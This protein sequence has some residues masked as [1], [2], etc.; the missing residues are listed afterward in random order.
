MDFLNRAWIQIRDLFLSMT[1]AA[2]VTTAVLLGVIVVSLGYLFTSRVSTT[3]SYLMGGE[4]FSPSDLKAME[5]AF[6]KAG[7][8]SYQIEGS[9]VRIP[10]GQEAKYMAALVDHNALPPEF[11][12][13]LAKAV[14]T[15]SPFLTAKQIESRKIAAKERE[16]ALIIRSL[17][18]IE[19]AAVLFD[20]QTE[21]GLRAGVVKTASVAVKALG[22][23]PLDPEQ[24]R[25]IRH[26][27]AASFAGMKPDNVTVADL[28][29]QTYTGSGDPASGGS[30]AD[31]PYIARKREHEKDW[32]LKILKALAYVPGITVTTNVEL[33]RQQILRKEDIKHD[34]KPVPIRVSETESSR[35]REGGGPGG[36]PGYVAQQ[37]K[38]NAPT[39][40][41]G[42]TGTSEQEEQSKSETVNALSTQRS[43][44]E[45]I[46]LTPK[47]VTAAIGVPMSYFARVW[48]ERNPAAPGEAPKPPDAAQLAKIR[49]E[50]LKKIRDHVAAILPSAEGVADKTELVT[51][52]EF[53]D[54]PGPEIP[55]PSWL[56]RFWEFLATSWATLGMLGLAAMSLW[57]IRSLSR[58]SLPPLPSTPNLP[59]LPTS[60]KEEEEAQ[61][62]PR[63][64]RFAAGGPSLKDELADLVREDPEAA[65]NILRAWIGTPQ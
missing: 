19:K 13:F 26:L 36:R 7:L 41:S 59:G 56:E 28:N 53:Q 30:A 27:V 9:R 39:S 24:V 25:K 42:R 22:A 62:G 29:G 18:G 47:R 60:E 61:K 8:S 45:E 5:A 1:P 64:A 15:S 32:Q 37:P 23:Q 17:P 40:V 49:D 43:M 10:R 3:E 4:S 12:E 58:A 55:T 16:L 2:R 50:E 51:V 33:D 63:F 65:A 48:E 20:A 52:T 46:G 21:G 14:E 38:A 34:P 57:M 35:T 44:V 31:D 6:G 11:G 54:I